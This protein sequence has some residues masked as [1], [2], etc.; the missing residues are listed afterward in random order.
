MMSPDS[1]MKYASPLRVEPGASRQAAAWLLLVHGAGLMMLPFLALPTALRVVLLAASV[2]LFCMGWKRHVHRTG[3]HAVQSFTWYAGEECT[4]VY[5][6]GNEIPCTLINQAF[7]MP[8][9][10]IL[11][12]RR[13]W[14]RRS[15]FILPDMLP[16]STFRRLR[17]RLNTE[18]DHRTTTRPMCASTR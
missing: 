2:G 3:R 16:A 11:H 18:L 14:R 4:V 17:V 5:A 12:Y 1:S 10:V 13:G 15:L 6:D 8:W 7:I 9:L